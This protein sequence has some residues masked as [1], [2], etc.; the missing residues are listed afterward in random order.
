V[1][2]QEVLGARPG[3][4]DH[5]LHACLWRELAKA[6]VAAKVYMAKDETQPKTQ[7]DAYTQLE[8][9][10]KTQYLGKLSSDVQEGII[11]DPLV[12]LLPLDAYIEGV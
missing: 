10:V 5:K 1:C 3:S 12:T 11:T 8:A 2:T 7:L 9:L 6:G 4:K